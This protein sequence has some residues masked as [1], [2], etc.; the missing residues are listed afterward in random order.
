[1]TKKYN[2]CLT[3]DYISTWTTIEATR[4]LIQNALDCG[5]YNIYKNSWDEIVIETTAGDM[6]L[7]EKNIDLF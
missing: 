3:K 6:V 7:E 5:S 2:T 4:E 1:M